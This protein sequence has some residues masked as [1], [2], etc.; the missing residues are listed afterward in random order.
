MAGVDTGRE[1]RDNSAIGWVGRS[2][3]DPYW[4]RC[5]SEPG[6]VEFDSLYDAV[7]EILIGRP[8]RVL[9][10]NVL[11]LGPELRTS[12]KSLV[13]QGLAAAVYVYT[14]VRQD[15]GITPNG[16][17]RVVFVKDPEQLMTSLAAL[18]S[19]P[20]AD[21]VSKPVE[22]DARE[23]RPIAHWPEE[24]PAVPADGT[25]RNEDREEAAGLSSEP[26]GSAPSGEEEQ[27]GSDAAKEFQVAELTQEELQ[28][29]LGP[30]F[31]AEEEKKD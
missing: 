7:T 9:V 15:L 1:G 10:V 27:E 20:I 5:S 8:V 19:P 31:R 11:A 6:I 3:D 21:A 24:P 22:E 14:P 2:C 17:P 26:A 13:L 23:E 29:L 25:I 4:A 16:D 28:A 18:E 12:L 30:E